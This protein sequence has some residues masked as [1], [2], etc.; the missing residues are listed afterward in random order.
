M[1]VIVVNVV[2]E[3]CGLYRVCLDRGEVRVF[4]CKVTAAVLIIEGSRCVSI[5]QLV[6]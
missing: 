3:T 1:L 4:A 2:T 6:K 5:T